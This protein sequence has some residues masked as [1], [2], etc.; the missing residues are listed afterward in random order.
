MPGEYKFIGRLTKQQ[1]KDLL[2]ILKELLYIYNDR[3]PMLWRIE[4]KPETYDD[5]DYNLVPDYFRMLQRKR[6]KDNKV[7][8]VICCNYPDH[9]IVYEVTFMIYRLVNKR[10]NKFIVVQKFLDALYHYS[11]KKL[12][13]ENISDPTIVTIEANLKDKHE[14]W[15]L[16]EDY[17]LFV[18][19]YFTV[20]FDFK[21]ATLTL[22]EKQL[23]DLKNVEEAQKVIYKKAIGDILIAK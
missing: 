4:N 7:C 9:G 6:E 2:G 3:L 16:L 14:K 12:Y 18:D 10:M 23:E 15:A 20:L 17:E 13:V 1:K 19:H 21:R 11:E 8:P 5:L 22:D